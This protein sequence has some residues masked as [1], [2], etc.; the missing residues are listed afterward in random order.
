MILGLNALDVLW[1][2]LVHIFHKLQDNY[3]KIMQRKIQFVLTIWYLWL[4]ALCGATGATALE[5]GGY[6]T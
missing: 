5:V 2:F 6:K 1:D 3:D 4:H